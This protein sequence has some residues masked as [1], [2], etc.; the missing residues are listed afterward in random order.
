MSYEIKNIKKVSDAYQAYV[1]LQVA[2]YTPGGS[3]AS[4]GSS[5]YC[6]AG[7]IIARPNLLSA[8]KTLS[9]C[10]DGGIHVGADSFACFLDDSLTFV[11]GGL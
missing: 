10:M 5:A 4:G 2:D 8:F 9:S 7:P 3:G 11:Y 1:N 6:S